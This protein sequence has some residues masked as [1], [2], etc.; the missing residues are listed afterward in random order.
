MRQN[1]DH[2]IGFRVRCQS[3]VDGT[4]LI[5]YATIKI[6]SFNTKFKCDIN[7]IKFFV[8]RVPSYWHWEIEAWCN[9]DCTKFD[10]NFDPA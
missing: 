8:N 1:L 10:S 2:Y 7:T 3:A 5:W 6:I 9:V 4:C